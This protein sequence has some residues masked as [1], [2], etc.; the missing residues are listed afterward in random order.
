MG[1]EGQDDF[2][3]DS[4]T[5]EDQD[6]H[7]HHH[8]LDPV[9]GVGHGERSAYFGGLLVHYPVIS[10]DRF[11]NSILWETTLRKDNDNQRLKITSRA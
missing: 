5:W 2:P 3:L 1:E 8:Q 7:H 9:P 4:I 10:Q 11:K 6:H